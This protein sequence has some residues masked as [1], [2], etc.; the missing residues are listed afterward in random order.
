[1]H[2]TPVGHGEDI[3]MLTKLQRRVAALVQ[4][5]H[6]IDS[7]VD[8]GI[9]QRRTLKTWDLEAVQEEYR[10]S[11]ALPPQKVALEMRMLAGQA[12][13]TLRSCMAE[14]NPQTR[15]LAARYV[16]DAVIAQADGAGFD[17]DAGVAELRD[18]LT[19]VS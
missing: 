1:M 18:L 16:L 13:H 2:P 9:V 17:D 6:T 8:E 3:T 4:A 5:G 19:L 7:I 10:R 14:G 15:L 12:L 11:I